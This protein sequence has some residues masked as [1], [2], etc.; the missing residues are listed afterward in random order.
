MATDSL[1]QPRSTGQ[2]K[3]QDALTAQQVDRLVALLDQ[4]HEMLRDVLD[5]LTRHGGRR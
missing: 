3:P 2:A 4:T 5:A 1:T